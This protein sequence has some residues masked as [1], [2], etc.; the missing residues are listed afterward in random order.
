MKVSVI[1][2]TY[3]GSSKIVQLLDSLKQQTFRNFELIISIDG[4][5]DDTAQVVE[6]YVSWFDMSV[7]IQKNGGR[8]SAKNNGAKHAKGDLLIFYDDDMEPTM[9]SIQK[10]IDFHKNK[11]LAILAGNPSEMESEVN[12]DIQNYKAWLASHWMKKYP[13]TIVQLTRQDLFLSA[14]NFSIAKE[15]FDNLNGFD[16]R[17]TD[18]EDF[19]LG[20]RAIINQIPVYFDKTNRAIHH[21][22]IT[23]RSYIARQ[24]QYQSAH[25]ALSTLKGEGNFG[26]SKGFKRLIYWMLAFRFLVVFVDR[27]L[28]TFVLPKILRYKLY[29]L[30]IH[31]LSVEFPTVKIQ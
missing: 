12:T 10:H 24:R 25:Q 5:T 15:V 19:D 13:D 22:D 30:I 4:S 26:K 3:N 29:T 20:C 23:C 1:I 21:D 18:A 7:F 28:F 17:L 9:D 27:S 14:A 16:V 6:P 2:P 8:S 31:S 11:G